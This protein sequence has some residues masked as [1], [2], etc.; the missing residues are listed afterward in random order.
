MAL[1]GVAALGV[2]MASPYFYRWVDS[3]SPY[4]RSASLEIGAALVGGAVVGLAV[5]WIERRQEALREREQLLLLLRLQRDH[6]SADPSGENLSGMRLRRKQFG[7]AYL[8][9]TNLAG[10]DLTKCRLARAQLNGADLHGAIL[11][12][13]LFE[14]AVL[15]GADLSGA[16]MRGTRLD[17]ASLHEANLRGVIVTGVNIMG[18]DSRFRCLT[19]ATLIDVDFTT[20][21]LTRARLDGLKVDAN[22]KGKHPEN[23]AIQAATVVGYE[24]PRAR[25][26]GCG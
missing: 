25:S 4:S 24:P 16:S 19:G 18:E 14:R 10:A 23:A 1:V 22:T 7:G 13:A 15:D 20:S 3:W 21:R 11:D 12:G 17:Y 8:V 2:V 26:P 5:V 9:R 6:S